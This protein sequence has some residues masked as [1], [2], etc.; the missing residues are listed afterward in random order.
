MSRTNITELKYDKHKLRLT[1][2]SRGGA[3]WRY[4]PVT[5]E[6]YSKVLKADDKVKAV[7]KLIR[8]SNVVG[9]K[10]A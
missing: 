4:Y 3:V 2:I 5:V 8:T 1:V 9:V 7:H 10:D 6:D